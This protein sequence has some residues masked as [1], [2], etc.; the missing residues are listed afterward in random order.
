MSNKKLYETI[1]GNLHQDL[2]AKLQNFKED[3]VY[4]SIDDSMSE[5]EVLKQAVSSPKT[6]I[7]HLQNQ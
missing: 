6:S 3:S 1:I 4:W 2:N 5:D 7:R